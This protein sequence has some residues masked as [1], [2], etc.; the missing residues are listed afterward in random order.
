MATQKTPSPQK[1]PQI[2][3]TVQAVYVPGESRPEK[4]YYFFAY[5]VHIK[6]L[7]SEPAQLMNRHW[8]I[9]DSLGRVEEV[10]GPGV[11]GLQPRIQPGTNFEYE[12]ACPLPTASGSMKGTYGLQTDQ[13]VAFEV[14]ISEFDL[15]APQ[16]LH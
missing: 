4:D 13:G 7:G 8:V 9:T 14:E 5:R 12:S 1:T 10:R 3:V 16:A 2:Q 11:V 6:N 15:V